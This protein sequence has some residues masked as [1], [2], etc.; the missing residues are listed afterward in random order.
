MS[1]I[2]NQI[3][4]FL[5]DFGKLTN[6]PLAGIGT[7]GSGNSWIF[8]SFFVFVVFLIGFTVGRTRMFTALLSIYGAAYLES[9]FPFPLKLFGGIPEYLIHI[10]LFLV[11][12]MLIFMV[13]SHS[14]LRGRLSTKD[15]SIPWIIILA[16]FEIGFL[17]SI[18][19][20]YL[21]DQ[22]NLLPMSLPTGL[23][24]IFNTKI[25]RFIWAIS[26]IILAIFL[27]GKKETPQIKISS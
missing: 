4:G 5:I 15:M 20:S 10:S 16:I 7:I 11:F 18:F 19:V 13:L 14:I 25:A 1:N 24:F 9:S 22:T 27:K 2:I 23:L 6:K 26:P 8:I 12:Y 3:L 21:G 17:C